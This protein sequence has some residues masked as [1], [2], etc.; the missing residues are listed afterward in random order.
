MLALLELLELLELARFVVVRVTFAHADDPPRP[1]PSMPA[2]KAVLVTD[3]KRN[4][5]RAVPVMIVATVPADMVVAQ[6]GWHVLRYVPRMR[7]NPRVVAIVC[8][9]GKTADPAAREG[10]GRNSKRQVTD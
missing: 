1:A 10:N 6:V 2:F 4:E 9:N 3:L 7:V 5:R 8:A